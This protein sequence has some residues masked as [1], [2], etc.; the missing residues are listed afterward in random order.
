MIFAPADLV[1][2]D[3]ISKG[4]VNKQEAK[5]IYSVQKQEE[6]EKYEKRVLDRNPSGYM[7]VE[8]YE[9]LST[10]KDRM[11]IDIEVPQTPTPPDLIY[12][13]KPTYK[14][15]KYNNPPGGSEISLGTSFYKRRQQNAQGIVSPDFSMLVYPSVYYYPNSA[16]T[17]CDLFVIKLDEAKSNQE[18]ILTANVMHRE[19]EPILSTEKSNDNYYTFRTLTPVDFSA[20][21][22]KLLVKEKIGNTKDGIWKTTPIV[23]DFNKKVSYNLIEVRGAI[24]YYWER[25]KSLQLDD[26]RWDIY[27]LGFDAQ[28]PD[29]VIV[30]AVAYTGN[31]PVNLGIWK[32]TYTGEQSRLVTF[33]NSAVNVSM[34]GFKLV[35]SGV[36]PPAV[37]Q[38]EE[39]YLKKVEKDKVKQKKKDDK[40][41]VKELKKAYK[42][43]LKEMDEEFK[44]SQKDYDL[45]QKINSSTSG[46]EGL[47]KYKEIKEEQEAKRLQDLERK[48][49]KVLKQIEKDQKR[50]EA[51]NK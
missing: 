40:A 31:E 47:E 4:D 36:E 35:T 8:E 24:V 43:K 26:K 46:N 1:A 5:Y 14:I 12:V 51:K 13:P 44:S 45:R 30:S 21:G 20:D 50:E 39:D 49:A 33:K 34:N 3:I 6:K 17:A 25:Y 19:S 37:T 9:L 10:P 27:P 48:K 15:E 28:N 41:E 42:A 2:W 7:T 16:S 22:S 32:V 38:R 18:K 29:W 23:Y 11:T